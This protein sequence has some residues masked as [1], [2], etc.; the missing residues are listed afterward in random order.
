MV[1]PAAVGRRRLRL[2]I[3]AGFGIADLLVLVCEIVAGRQDL[4]QIAAGERLPGNA[5][6]SHKALV[7]RGD[8]APA[9]AQSCRSSNR[10]HVVRIPDLCIYD[11]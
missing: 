7:D 8:R 10:A 1:S 6:G 5:G 3:V 11:I 4:Q 2:A 9:A